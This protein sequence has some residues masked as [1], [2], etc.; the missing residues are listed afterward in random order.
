[1]KNLLLVVAIMAATTLNAQDF[2]KHLTTARSAYAGKKL[3]DSRFAMQQ[4]LQELELLTGKEI[5]RT[6]P[7]QL[8]ELKA[9]TGTDEVT[10]NSLFA[11]VV[12]SRDYASASGKASVELIGNSPLL[13][14]VNALLT[15]PFLSGAGENQKVVKVQGYKALLQKSTSDNGRVAYELQLPLSTSLLSLK[16][17]D[18]TE[19]EVLSAV[20]AL[21]IADLVKNL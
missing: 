2:A 6:L 4:M 20:Q 14:S 12:I 13:S 5:L 11:G 1:M 21:P 16:T 10:A 7:A 19:D 18:L 3:E 8:N 15:M 17:T 9:V